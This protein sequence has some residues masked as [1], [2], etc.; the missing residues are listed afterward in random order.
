MRLLFLIDSLAVGGAEQSLLA[1]APHLMGKGVE[2][3]VGF[4]TER[5]GIGP[6][7]ETV[8]VELHSLVGEGGRLAAVRRTLAAINRIQPELVHTTLFEADLVG[9]VAAIRA[10]VPVVSSFVTEAYGPEHYGNPE[11]RRWKVRGAHVLDAATARLVRRFHAV[12]ESAAAVMAQRL[13]ISPDRVTVIPRGRDPER[14]GRRTSERRT[15]ARAKLGVA[16]DEALVL[17]AGRH[18]HFKGLDVLV[19]AMPKVRSIIPTARLVVAGREGPATPELRELIA[20]G[21]VENAV[22]LI[23]Y[24]TDIPDLMTAADVFVLPSR[25]EGSPGAL[26]EAMA[27]EVPVV[28]A[29]IPSVRE[30]AGDAAPTMLL[31]PPDAPEPLAAAVADVLGDEQ[32]AR[33]LAASA[34]KRFLDAYT[35]D[36]VADRTA[37]LYRSVL[38]GA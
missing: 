20:A 28:A 3:H 38:A 16:D 11:Y 31:T 1:L 12:S 6:D 14:L 26:I 27:L 35:I 33:Q 37:E 7:L 32:A 36:V 22:D 18:F 4:L 34:Y 15:A 2:L 29:D 17:A 30:I 19:A 21:G 23:G 24:R 13:R 9:R 5:D 25:A 10:R 8:G